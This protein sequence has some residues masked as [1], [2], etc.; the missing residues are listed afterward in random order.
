MIGII[1]YILAIL[2]AYLFLRFRCGLIQNQSMPDAGKKTSE[3][4]SIVV[5]FRNEESTL[6]T[7]LNSLANQTLKDFQLIL[8]NDHS[9]DNYK[10]IIDKWSC[11]FPDFLLIHLEEGYGKKIA[12]SKGV[13][14][15]KCNNILVTD[16]DCDLPEDWS[17]LMGHSLDENNEVQ[18]VAGIVSLSG[19]S[20]F[21]RLQQLEFASLIASSV[22]A[23][24]QNMAF[25]L[26]AASM[27]FKKSFYLSVLKELLSVPSPSGDDVFLL[28][29]CKRNHTRGFRYIFDPSILVKTPAKTT[30]RAFLSQ[31]IRWAS[32]ATYYKDPLIKKIAILVG[33]THIALLLGAVSLLLNDS[34]VYPFFIF[35]CIKLVFDFL[36]LHRYLQIVQQLHLLNY[37]LI[38]EFVLPFYIIFV[39]IS[40]QFVKYSWKDRIYRH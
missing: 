39:G 5:A 13:Q 11:V 36:L 38:V 19:N 33:V 1:Y 4:L 29:A 30:L 26:N 17:R 22:G 31:R 15:A 23:A 6:D 3:K 14:H 37:F 28:S 20:F 32:K 24:N 27:G 21:Q 8:V 34:V 18:L 12:I 16:A 25:M 35:V 9:T 7:L 40:S 10:P 2:Y